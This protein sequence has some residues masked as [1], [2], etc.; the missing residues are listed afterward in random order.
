MRTRTLGTVGVLILMA[1]G[2]AQPAATRPVQAVAW[3]GSPQAPDTSRASL[4]ATIRAAEARLKAAPTDAGAAVRLAD[5]LMRQARVTGNPGLA[6]RAERALRTVLSTDVERYD[7]RRMLATVLLSEHRFR[8]AIREAERCQQIHPA[9]AWS[10][11]VIGDAHLELGEYEAAFAA[12][13]RMEARRPDAASYARLAYARELQGD[14]AG[15]VRVMTMA[16]E[17]TSPGDPESQAWHHAQ[18][19]HLWLAQDRLSDAAREFDHANYI[20]PGHPFA[21]EGLARVASRQGRHAEALALVEQ[22]IA[23]TPAPAALAFAAEELRAVGRADDAARQEALAEAAWRTDAP[24]PARLALFL[25]DRPDRTPSQI[26]E[27]VQLAEAASR[28]RDDIFTNDAL[29]WAYFRAGRLSDAVAASARALR[30]G[31]VDLVLRRHAA[32]IASAAASTKTKAD[33]R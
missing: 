31:S 10:L 29:A 27:A 7:A 6:L 28:D 25:A 19:G 9:D 12:F 32:A 20:F 17:A 33:A 26:E 23:A 4:D 16:L 15:A 5:A 24:E 22:L 8:D 2:C 1:A 18:L 14:L 11:G 30:T 21:I 3:L 13:G